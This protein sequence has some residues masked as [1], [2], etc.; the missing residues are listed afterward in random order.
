[1]A[2]RMI[3]GTPRRWKICCCRASAVS[4]MNCPSWSAKL[5]HWLH[6]RPLSARLLHK[7]GSTGVMKLDKEEEEEEEEEEEL[8]LVHPRRAMS[9]PPPQC[10]KHIPL[11]MKKWRHGANSDCVAAGSS[12]MATTYY[13]RRTRLSHRE[14]SFTSSVAPSLEQPLTS[15]T[16][17]C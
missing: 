3:S 4:R 5:P 9:P 15:P 13:T 7:I 12:A 16:A 17:T 14:G 1:M 2:M 8:H 11:F 6:A 10:R